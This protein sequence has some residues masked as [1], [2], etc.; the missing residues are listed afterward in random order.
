MI[1]FK[2]FIYII[3]QNVVTL[4]GYKSNS[5]KQTNKQAN[6]QTKMNKQKKISKVCKKLKK[7]ST[8]YCVPVFAVGSCVARP[9]AVTAVAVL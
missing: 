7:N 1:V 9:R 8:T 6:K 5:Q 3:E 2:Y 4:L